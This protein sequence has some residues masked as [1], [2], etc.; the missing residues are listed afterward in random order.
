MTQPFAFA[1]MDSFSPVFRHMVA[2]IGNTPRPWLE[3]VLDEESPVLGL[4]ESETHAEGG[5]Q[6]TVVAALYADI[7]TRPADQQARLAQ[8]LRNT[9]AENYYQPG[10]NNLE[11]HRVLHDTGAAAIYQSL[12]ITSPV[13]RRACFDA[14]YR[15]IEAEDNHNRLDIDLSPENF[16][17]RLA[18]LARKLHAGVPLKSGSLGVDPTDTVAT[19]CMTQTLLEEPSVARAIFR[20]A[21]EQSCPCEG[22][23]ELAFEDAAVWPQEVAR[24]ALIEGFPPEQV[25]AGTQALFEELAELANVPR[26]A[27]DAFVRKALVNALVPFREALDVLQP[28]VRPDEYFAERI[29]IPYAGQSI[30]KVYPSAYPSLSSHG[31]LSTMSTE[32]YRDQAGLEDRVFVEKV[33]ASATRDRQLFLD[34][35]SQRGGDIHGIQAWIINGKASGLPAQTYDALISLMQYEEI[36][37]EAADALNLATLKRWALTDYQ[38]GPAFIRPDDFHQRMSNLMARHQMLSPDA[39]ELVGLRSEHLSDLLSDPD[40]LSHAARRKVVELDFGL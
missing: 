21:F 15:A 39:I 17:P 29:D 37:G 34:L 24:L 8:R 38:R 1:A 14:L 9:L 5:L 26:L 10:L 31:L 30:F 19:A 6:L 2:N 35:L 11:V 7:L 13:A 16:A 23:D 27:V 12:E 40:A 33:L 18:R 28:A 36:G 4:I 20:A 3:E 25:V 22:R 32:R